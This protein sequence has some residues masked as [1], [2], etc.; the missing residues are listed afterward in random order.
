M[1]TSAENAGIGGTP[2]ITTIT[3]TATGKIMYVYV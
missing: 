1:A 3:I 2:T